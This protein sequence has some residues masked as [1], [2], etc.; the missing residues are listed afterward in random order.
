MLPPFDTDPPEWGTAGKRARVQT[1]PGDAFCFSSR[2]GRNGLSGVRPS[3]SL[4]QSPQRDDKGVSTAY[5]GFSRLLG[6]SQESIS[7]AET[8][9]SFDARLPK[10]E[11]GVPAFSSLRTPPADGRVL[12]RLLTTASD[13]FR[14][15]K[16]CLSPR[17]RHSESRF[18]ETQ[19][20]AS[21]ATPDLG[22]HAGD[23]CICALSTASR[24][25]ADDTDSVWEAAW[26]AERQPLDAPLP[27][28]PGPRDAALIG[29]RGA[30]YVARGQRRANTES[31]ASREATDEGDPPSAELPE[32]V[33]ER[34]VQRILGE[35]ASALRRYSV[36]GR[37]I[38]VSAPGGVSRARGEALLDDELLSRAFAQGAPGKLVLGNRSETVHADGV[39][40]ERNSGVNREGRGAAAASPFCVGDACLCPC[41]P[42]ESQ[43]GPSASR[44]AAECLERLRERNQEK[45]ARLSL[46]LMLSRS[47]L[48]SA[49]SR[50][51]RTGRLESDEEG[52]GRED[53]GLLEKRARHDI[54][55]ALR[56]SVEAALAGEEDWESARGLCD[57][58]QKPHV[59]LEG[60]R[61]RSLLSEVADRVEG[62]R[63]REEEPEMATC[64][65]AGPDGDD[66]LS[67][68][69]ARAAPRAFDRLCLETS[70]RAGLTGDRHSPCR[71][72]LSKSLNTEL[73]ALS[74]RARGDAGLSPAGGQTRSR[75]VDDDLRNPSPRE[76][77]T[78]SFPASSFFVPSLR[79]HQGRRDRQAPLSDPEASEEQARQS[80]LAA[81][82]AGFFV[83]QK[84]RSLGGPPDRET[85]DSDDGKSRRRGIARLTRA[86]S[87]GDKE[88]AGNGRSVA[89]LGVD[90]QRHE[91]NGRGD[92]EDR[93]L[94]DCW[95]IGQKDHF[96]EKYKWLFLS[97]GMLGCLYCRAMKDRGLRARKRGM[98]IVSH[99]ADGAVKPSGASR[100]TNMRS[101]RKK[102]CR[103]QDSRTHKEAA[104]L[105]GEA[106]QKDACERSQR[107]MYEAAKMA[108]LT[109]PPA[110]ADDKDDCADELH[111]DEASDESDGGE[112]GDE[113]ENGAGSSRGGRGPASGDRERLHEEEDAS[114][115]SRSK[116]EKREKKSV[117]KKS[118]AE[119][120][121]ASGVVGSRERLGERDE[122]TPLQARDTKAVLESGDDTE[123]QKQ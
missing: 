103:H 123:T 2:T 118:S 23:G 66:R 17:S 49:T 5:S 13:I 12:E 110:A 115:N 116:E 97:G 108:L 104:E 53:G 51:P 18:C 52:R 99:W 8:S 41:G 39:R 76:R 70:L 27:C 73:P 37:D 35:A 29:R 102:I 24:G 63:R 48:H 47:P 87:P 22:R 67:C 82:D 1:D 114:V 77:D 81:A 38:R 21:V 93:N 121:E 78:A 40:L 7:T 33:W 20:S 4:G 45:A 58:A 107:G 105:L 42:R 109:S 65:C 101:L 15:P 59:D 3:G 106:S 122:E 96:T 55:A 72:T 57:R 62:K 88:G 25:S 50:S 36:E 85:E 16:R 74:F 79:G 119:A 69:S 28:C 61:V 54:P 34:S 31:L 80:D 89:S 26:P 68:F 46:A 92:E 100:V 30:D 9:V 83:P 14:L 94:P 64:A 112:P 6:T 43:A 86:T 10:C 44:E 32:D 56:S 98:K 117:E 75:C 113:P 91:R 90:A 60:R 84:G 19:R 95:T 120:A 111:S 11:V 71:R